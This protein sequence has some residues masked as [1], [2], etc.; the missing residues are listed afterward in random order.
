MKKINNNLYLYK[1]IEVTRCY[2]CYYTYVSVNKKSEPVL[3][4]AP[5]QRGFMKVFN[6]F[7]TEN[8]GLV[9]GK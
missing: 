5:T 3:I 7:V 9:E 8:G 2:K 4:S 6:K 1:G